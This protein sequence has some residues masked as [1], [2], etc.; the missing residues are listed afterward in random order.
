MPGGAHPAAC[1]AVVVVRGECAAGVVPNT[2][3]LRDATGLSQEAAAEKCEMPTRTLQMIETAQGNVTA[4][5]LRRLCV[6]F[7]VDVVALLA[8]ASSLLPL[9]SPPKHYGER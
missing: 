5:T 3:C 6:R 4:T 8:P 1:A 7:G 9:S 2:R